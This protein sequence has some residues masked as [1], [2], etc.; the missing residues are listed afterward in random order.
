M[1]VGVAVSVEREAHSVARTDK[2]EARV[3]LNGWTQVIQLATSA[4][5]AAARSTHSHATVWHSAPAPIQEQG[6]A[7]QSLR[8]VCRRSKCKAEGFAKVVSE[9]SRRTIKPEIYPQDQDVIRRL[10]SLDC[11]LYDS[12][13]Q[14]S[15]GTYLS[16]G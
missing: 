12:V 2:P 7:I 6:P 4:G 10:T 11:I 14:V 13:N 8:V 16:S 9:R 3:A 15:L 1:A 5:P